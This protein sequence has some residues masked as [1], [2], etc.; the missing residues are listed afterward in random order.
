VTATATRPEA[1]PKV[2]GRRRPDKKIE[3][4]KKKKF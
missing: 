2:A 1:G 3:K 4:I